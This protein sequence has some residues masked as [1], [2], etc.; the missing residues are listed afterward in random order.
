MPKW[1]EAPANRE[2]VET[3]RVK[4]KYTWPAWVR[5]KSVEYL[6]L[7]DAEEAH[8]KARTKMVKDMWLE[9]IFP[10]WEIKRAFVPITQID[11]LIIE[12]IQPTEKIVSLAWVL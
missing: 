2:L 9:F 11:Y 1:K 12:T 3:Y 6:T 10:E 4:L 5:E 7:K 8:N